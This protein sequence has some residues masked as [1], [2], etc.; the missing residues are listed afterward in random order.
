MRRRRWP[1]AARLAGVAT[2]LAAGLAGGCGPDDPR[3]RQAV[4]GTVKLD[5]RPL[6]RGA[7]LLEPISAEDNSGTAAG[8]TIRS[9]SFAIRREQGPIPGHYR[10]RVYS[11]SG[12]LAPPG[13][14]QSE[15]TRRPIVELLPAAYNSQ[16][17]LS[18]DIVQGGSNR[19]VLDLHGEGRPREGPPR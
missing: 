12:A 15:R 16:S 7:I 9:G 1:R 5:G 3:P 18:F 4:S 8:A 17:T 19:L 2:I 10:V 11:S 6:E 14:G 13:P